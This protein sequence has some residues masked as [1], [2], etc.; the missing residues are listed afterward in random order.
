MASCG[1]QERELVCEGP[2]SVE[3]PAAALGGER[4]GTEEGVLR[5]HSKLRF[6]A[7]AHETAE[8]GLRREPPES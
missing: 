1:P 8:R 3:A 6:F 4:R 5:D 2:V 7:P